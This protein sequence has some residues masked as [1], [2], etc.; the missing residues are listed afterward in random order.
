MSY[1]SFR[2]LDAVFFFI[3]SQAFLIGFLVLLFEARSAKWCSTVVLF[4]FSITQKL[5][6]NLKSV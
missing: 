1:R 5:K 2:Y 6:Y 4:V 3:L